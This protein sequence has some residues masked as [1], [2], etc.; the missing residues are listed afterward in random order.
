MPQKLLRAGSLLALSWLIACGASPTTK[1]AAPA[2]TV[3]FSVPVAQREQPMQAAAD[4]GPDESGDL[5]PIPVTSADPSW[6]SH[7][8]PVTLVVFGDFQCPFCRRLA[9]TIDELKRA[10]G[11]K[12]LRVVWKNNPLPFHKEA[13]PAAETAMA[14]FEQ[15]GSEM[16]WGYHDAV[17]GNG[18]FG[19]EVYEGALS[20]SGLSREQINRVLARGA[21]V[22]KVDDDLE[23]AKR[24]GV[25]GTPMSFINGV[26]VSG[27]QPTENFREVIDAQLKEAR[28]AAAAGTPVRRVYVK[29]TEQNFVA[30]K[31]KATSSDPVD[32]AIHKVPIDGSPVHG[33]AAAL[34]TM[35]MFGDYQCPFCVRAEATVKQLESE[36]GDKLRV[37]WK[38][39]PLPFHPR[40]EPAAQLALEARAQKGDAGFW[41]AHELLFAQNGKLDDQDLMT[42][43]T[44][45][46]LNA[47]AVMKSVEKHKHA[48][49]IE[50]DVDLSDDL[51][52][53]GTPHFFIN[54]RRLVG[55]QPIEKFRAL[56]DEQIAAAQALVA[57]GTA[58]A[59]VYE[60]VQKNAVGPAP[61]ETVTVPAPTKDNPSRGPQ[62]A[63]VVIQIFSDFECPFCERVEPTLT[64]LDAAF[65]GKLRFVW[66][67]HPLPFHSHAQM[68][69]E[70]AMEAYRQKGATAFWK[71]HDLLFANQKGG[72]ERQ[73]LE[74]Y[75]QQ[76]G[77]DVAKFSA[78]L[79]SGAHRAA[80]EAD[81]KVAEGAGLSGTPNFAINGYKVS[82]AQPLTKFKKI[83][84]RALAEAK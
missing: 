10:Y 55:A 63:K 30:P 24:L 38:N 69:A 51:G 49:V 58:P 16:F 20:S 68:A 44:A 81:V 25:T 5:G 67:N 35:V 50:R 21:A 59:K 18:G 15:G 41:K 12:Q 11:P 39:N 72:L 57:Q 31:P 26:S 75:A 14:L 65:P 8:A 56:I 34:V 45:V 1:T 84:S 2:S 70:A 62:N 66:R 23:L 80:I 3:D 6:G 43:A 52:A 74:Q 37:V 71:M 40:A 33:N 48:A 13:R 9:G 61:L 19:P 78:A 77:L 47:A 29:L 22:K 42:V 82:G 28:A 7:A 73:S 53:N 36:Y 17:F 27:S 64:A 79:D 54:G 76:V 60:A 46:G 4:E 83:V 32:T